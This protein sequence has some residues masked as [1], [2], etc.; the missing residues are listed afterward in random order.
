M[1]PARP[2]LAVLL[3]YRLLGRRPA[4][5]HDD[6]LRTD[7]DSR[8]YPVRSVLLVT[9]TS[10]VV[11][12]AVCWAGAALGWWSPLDPFVVVA[13]GVVHGVAQTVR[14]VRLREAERERLFGV[15]DELGRFT[16]YL[17]LERDE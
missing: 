14:A 12:I 4:A 10:F 9:A 5:T 2:P 15:R 13:L 7:L 3:R 16:P 1:T 17:H 8:W 6:W 11:V